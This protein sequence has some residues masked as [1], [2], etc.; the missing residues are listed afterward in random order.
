[1]NPA[2]VPAVVPA[3]D[4]RPG[5]VRRL[6]PY[7]MAH[8]RN[9]EIALGG[10]LVGSGAQAVVPLVERQIVDNVIL[11][12]RSPLAPWL[13]LLVGLGVVTFA[14][15]YLRRY[16]GG[17][18]ALDVQYD[19]RN[20]MYEHLHELDFAQH[21]E[22]PTGQ[23]VG[24]ANSDSTLVQG[25]LSFFPIMSGNILLLLASLAIML[26][27]SP[28]LALVTIVVT[29]SLVV[30]AYRMRTQVF[31]ATW[32]GQQKEGDIAQIVDEDVSGVRVVKAFGQE[33]R[34]LD[35]IVSAT[36]TLY[37]SHMRAVRLQA[38]YQPLLQAIPTLGQVAVLAL[39]G[40]LALDHRIT[41]GTFLAFS[42]Y[43]AQLVS[44]ARML[45]GILTTAQQARAGIER[46][47]ELLDLRP[48]ITDKPQAPELAPLRGEITFD[49]VGFTYPDGGEALSDF[50]L[51]I[52][53]GETV[54]LV[55]PSGSGKSTVLALVARFYD[56]S[57][58]AVR[59][60]G[61]DVRDVARAS[62][63]RQ[64]GVVFDDSFLFSASVHANIAFG[65]PDATPAEVEAAARA[66][67][68][69]EFIEALP[70]GYE[71]VVGERGLT[72]S[73]G[74]RQRIALARAVLGGP[75]ILLL[76][77]ATSA[78]DAKVEQEIQTALHDVMRDRTT[79]LVAH[80]RSSL[81]LADRIVVV[82]GGRVVD[83]GSDAELLERCALYR[84]MSSGKDETPAEVLA[85]R[86]GA[87]SAAMVKGAASAGA[88]ATAPRVSFGPA[89]LG[90]GL[91]ARSPSGRG[92]WRASL[93]PTPE[94]LARVAALKPVRDVPR[95]DLAAET[96]PESE[97]S[98]WRFLGRFRGALGLGLVLVLFDSLA[99]LAG[100]YLVRA[101]INDG[102]VAGSRSAL[103]AA[104]AVF[105]AVALADLVDSVAET[106]V[107]GRTAER[108]M[109]ALR[110]RIW[111]KLQ[112][113]SLDYYEREMAGRIMTRMTTDVDS[114]ETLLETGL[115]SAVVSFCTFSGVG[116]A[117]F[118]LNSDLAIATL[119]V[120][121]PLAVAT[122]VFR[123]KAART[124]EQAR[125]RIAAV[126]ANFQESLSGIRE[127]QAFVHEEASIARF[128]R[129]GR[130][131][132]EARVRAQQMVATYFPFVQFLGDAGDAIVLGVGAGLVASGH[133]TT[134]ALIAFILYLD[135]FFS[136]IQQLSQVFDSWQ[137]TRVSVERVG[138]LMA[139]E[140]LTPE[141]PAPVTPER[142]KGAVKLTSVHFSYPTG[143]PGNDTA[144]VQ[145][146][147]ALRGV[148]L[149]I[150]PGEFVA[151]VGETGAGKSTVVKLLARFYDPTAGAVLVDGVDLRAYDLSAYRRQLG[152][153]PQEGFLFTGTIRDNIAYGRPDASD[154]AVEAAAVSVGADQFISE[155]ANG[156]GTAVSERGR[157]LSAGQRQLVALARAE[158]V[159]PAILLLDEATSNLD[160]VAEAHVASATG[161]VARGRTTVV[162]AHRLQTA[163]MADRIIVL[164]D[165][166]IAEQGT[167]EGLIAA[168]GRY[169]EMWKASDLG[170]VRT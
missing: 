104:S 136:P 4:R 70:E 69:H 169:A 3:E 16:R 1:M 125:D 64:V 42:T 20:A 73:G 29:P 158:L 7:L 165:G 128:R 13:A 89:S 152:Y 143:R 65:H 25:L 28:L 14:A 129:L 8:R 166:V 153:V 133:L 96:S 154:E 52:A 92:G 144:P 39:G 140:T 121:G 109:L 87:A 150:S 155:L 110:I 6:W 167:H 38:R 82:D 15:A 95:L 113:Q 81:H 160:L 102:V 120:M 72:L 49:H 37:G 123:R 75:R 24:R 127:T 74:Q 56:A 2:A 91:G 30:V 79:L 47:F 138:E 97:F 50:D 134:G 51:H 103:I 100:P 61:H 26:V 83:Q 45:A 105:L 168:G 159:D 115:L 40:W 78:V 132:L 55:G 146:I 170:L 112:R 84:S 141:A 151:L 10:A 66:A 101:G 48:A 118:F 12:H 77:D 9:L 142:L 33:E 145:A 60:D 126:N 86:V 149:E 57:S 58:G 59:L 32:D 130:S 80:R 164:A 117:L 44:P 18:V 108:L 94:L 162:I 106:F 71:T 116:V 90:P 21:D 124:Y 11:H 131:Y 43:L 85:A 88:A 99:S 34:E 27:L 137:Q 68:A 35:R 163:R 36:K 148:D 161:R 19:L 156:Y 147:E 114:F 76:D 22:M 53:P 107:T 5:W 67:G 62:L 41:I 98:L 135:L 157:S 122:V 119:G 31:P 93:A 17:R 63:R 111:A 46:I 54:A 139:L 23:L